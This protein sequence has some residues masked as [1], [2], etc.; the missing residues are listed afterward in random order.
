M[1]KTTITTCVGLLCLLSTQSIVAEDIQVPLK[2]KDWQIL[3][4]SSIKPNSVSFQS[5]MRIEVDDSASPLIY[6]LP[7][8]TAVSSVTLKAR[9]LGELNLDGQKQGNKKADDFV[10]RLGLVYQGDK[11]LGFLQR[12]FAADWILKLYSLAPEKTG[13]DRIEFFN[14]ISNSELLGKKRQHPASDYLHE[15]FITEIGNGT[16]NVT[17]PVPEDQKVL[18]IWLSSDG[19][20]TG[21]KYVVDLEKITLHSSN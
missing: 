5:G 20:D 13:I 19:D 14:V 3:T 8:P 1:I 9:I 15:N 10:F 2:E 11:K 4:Y 18:A 6:P 7:A 16:I 12:V 21:S 17:I